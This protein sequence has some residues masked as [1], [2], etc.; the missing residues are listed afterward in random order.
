MRVSEW[1]NSA[2][3][4]LSS[5][6]RSLSEFLLFRIVC[7]F[8]KMFYINIVDYL[9]CLDSRTTLKLTSIPLQPFCWLFHQVLVG[10]SSTMFNLIDSQ[11]ILR[12]IQIK[13]CKMLFRDLSAKW[14]DEWSVTT[15]GSNWHWSCTQSVKADHWSPWVVHN[16][17][18][19]I[20]ISRFS[21]LKC[22]TH[23]IRK[24]KS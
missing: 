9:L 18:T 17:F 10:V 8:Q 20:C 16:I 1:V 14:V 13:S 23:F 21:S 6:K 5:L 24:K 12:R 3:F 4:V 11:T 2:W 19:R 22:E 15:F 7:A